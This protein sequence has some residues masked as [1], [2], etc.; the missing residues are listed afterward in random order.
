MANFMFNYAAYLF[1]DRD[2]AETL[3]LVNDSNLQWMLINS[4]YT[5]GV[6]TEYVDEGGGSDILD[7]EITATNYSGG[8]AGTSRKAFTTSRQ[9]TLDTSN[10]LSWFDA[11]DPATWSS[12]GGATNDTI[13]AAILIRKGTSDD[14]DALVIL[15][16]DTVE[17]ATYP[18]LPYTT[19][20]GDFTLQIPADGIL[21][22]LHGII[23]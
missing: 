3:D 7:A 23:T 5:P 12:L 8:W 13:D 11:A 14:T 22:L 18:E 20:G 15:Y 17:A 16:I 10:D 6:N 2:D 19:N 4:D 21:H 1:A 9:W